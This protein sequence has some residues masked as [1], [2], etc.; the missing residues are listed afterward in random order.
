[1]QYMCSLSALR[2]L[3]AGEQSQ[4]GR[5]QRGPTLEVDTFPT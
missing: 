2:R 4:P 5:R 1:M 3:G